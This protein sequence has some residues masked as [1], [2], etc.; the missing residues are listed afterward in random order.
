MLALMLSIFCV[1]CSS[2]VISPEILAEMKV[3]SDEYKALYD[4][5]STSDIA[6]S[7]QEWA[8][9][10]VQALACSYSAQIPLGRKL[11]LDMRSAWQQANSFQKEADSL[12][13]KIN[14][15]PNEAEFC[16]KYVRMHVCFAKK[17]LIEHCIE[18]HSKH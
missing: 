16:A 1:S 13:K 4:E 9:L 10:Q 18:L 17:C 3:C 12:C 5:I 11:N 6:L 15:T 8:Y 7:E 14:L 2:N